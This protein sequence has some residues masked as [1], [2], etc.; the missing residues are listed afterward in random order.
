MSFRVGRSVAALVVVAAC[1]SFVSAAPAQ[2]VA[3]GTFK[4]EGPG[5]VYDLGK[6]SPTAPS[7]TS[8]AIQAILTNPANAAD[9]IIGTTNGGLWSTTNGGTSWTPLTDNAASLSIASLAYNST[10]SSVIYAGIGQTDNGL[11]ASQRGAARLGIMQS[12]DGGA[13]WNALSATQLG[14]LSSANSGGGL[15]VVGV[16]GYTQGSSTTILAATWEPWSADKSTGASNYGLYMSVG[17]GTF[18]LVNDGTGVMPKGAATSLVGQGTVANP[19]YVA[20]TADTAASSGVFRSTNGG[21][22]WTEV[23]SLGTITITNDNRTTSTLGMAG[24]LAVGPNGSVAV[25]VFNPYEKNRGNPTGGTMLSLELSQTGA[26]GSWIAASTVPPVNNGGQAPTNLAIAIDPSSSTTVYVAGDSIPN[27]PFTLSAYRVSFSGNGSTMVPITDSGTAD[28]SSVHADSRV[29]T[30]DQSGR[31]VLSNDGGIYALT[32]PG[33]GTGS[34]SSLNGNLQLREAY[35]VAYDAVSHRLVVAAQDNGVALQNAPGAQAGTLINGGDGIVAAVNDRTYAAEGDSIIYHSAQNFGNLTREVL[36]SSGKRVN[37]INFGTPTSTDPIWNFA[38]ADFGA[39]SGGDPDNPV[40]SGVKELPF[41]SQ[42]ILNRADPTK[43]ALGTNFVYVTTDDLITSGSTTPLTNVVDVTAQPKGLIG[44]VS[45]L[46]YGVYGYNAAIDPDGGTALLVGAN[47]KYDDNPSVRVAPSL[48]YSA[49]AGEGTLT[50]LTTYSGGIP[51]SMVFG[52]QSKFFYVADG[53]TL[54]TS[55]NGGTTI[56]AANDNVLANGTN[57]NVGTPTAVEFI[58]KNGVNALLVGG[59]N[60]WNGTVGSVNS[61]SPIAVSLVDANG[62]LK[63]GSPFGSGLPNTFANQIVFNPTADVLA[64]SLYGRGIWTMYDVTSRFSTATTLVFGSAGNDSTPGADILTDGVDISG[65]AFPRGLRKEGSGTLTIDVPASYSNGTTVAAGTLLITGTGT[66]GSTSAATTVSGGTL[67]LGGTTQTQDGGLTLTGGTVQN[68]TFQSNGG[69]TVQNGTISAV[70]AGSSGL[71]KSGSSTVLL[72]GTNTYT[73]S[74]SVT[75]GTLTVNG[76]IASSSGVT[77]GVD[78]V[79]GGSGTLPATVVNGFVAPNNPGGILTVNNSFTQNAGS[80]YKAVVMAGGQSDQIKV[81]GAASLAGSVAVL[82]TAGAYGSGKTFTLLTATAV[83]GHY[84]GATSSYAFLRPTLSYDATDVFLTL[85]P[86][87]FSQAAATPSQAAVAGVLDRNV[88][89]ASGD[90]L[91]VIDAF[92]LMTPAQASTAFQAISGQNYAGF[93]S[94]GVQTAQLFMNFFAVQAG[95]AQTTGGG[96]GGS[97]VAMAEACDVACDASETP[98]WSAWGG[99]VGGVGTIAGSAAAPGQNFNIGGFAAG[100]DRRFG[101]GLMFGVTAGYTAANQYT[102]T[103]PGQGSANTVQLGFYGEYGAGNFYLDALAGYAHSSNQMTRSIS[104]AG[105]AQRTAIGKTTTEQFFGQLEAGYKIALGGPLSPFVTP[106]ARLQG[107]TASQAG[108]TESGAD[109]IDLTV[110][111]QTTNSLRTVLGAQ[112]GASIDLGWREKLGLVLR[113]GW[114]HEY[115]DT[116]RPVN[117]SF[118]GAPASPFTVAGAEAPR[119]GAIVGL[120][121]STAI[122]EATSLYLRYDGE[123]AGGNT[124]HIVSAG[125]RIIW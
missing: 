75:A 49:T 57:L 20:I 9:M 89:T 45:A 59:L 44:G 11:V 109:S 37:K 47:G 72:S 62:N 105:L 98:R 19:Y 70:L 65:T 101:G 123:L 92:S 32:N 78:G 4:S 84:D 108:F 54:W 5:P 95:G 23:L 51:T 55:V 67:D 63:P 13:T 34:W 56:T 52:S 118:A 36:D 38:P 125:L 80:T 102:Q 69:F 76:S 12:P 25:A 61:T 77:V 96:G 103:M 53:A 50:K 112:A 119:D 93:S 58:N 115:A 15:S 90:F 122:A 91:S 6:A 10:N 116:S 24:R 87:G 82:P 100:I 41:S 22:T 64:V 120:A 31:M 18:S 88:A 111:G 28:G 7:T 66:L 99:P 35:S 83:T 26:S 43:I 104:L 117:A 14:P 27:G 46:A 110:A 107:S 42:L 124:S 60:A 2:T 29:I 86:G 73:G 33:T 81:N 114:S 40:P 30:F 113:L 121:A 79:L 48:W 3:T 8:G 97:R 85:T 1:V 71:T 68:G 17:G 106:F 74:T 39:G 21:A 16:A 94:L